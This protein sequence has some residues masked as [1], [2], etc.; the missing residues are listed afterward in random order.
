MT[1]IKT[2]TVFYSIQG[3]GKYAGVPSV[4]VRTFGCNFRCKSFGIR[5]DTN[6]SKHNAEVAEI[7][8]NLSTYATIDDMP[9]VTTGCDS[10]SSV[11]PEFKS[12]AVDYTPEAL[13]SKVVSLLPYKEWRDEHLV[14][15]GGE[16]LLGWQD[17]YPA[18]LDDPQMDKL[19]FLTFETN[20]TQELSPEFTR[21]LLSWEL[22]GDAKNGEYVREVTFSVSPKL[23]CSGE[24][25][26]KA[27]LPEIV[28]AYQDAGNVFLKFV[29]TDAIDVEE[30]L[31]YI[32]IYRAAGVVCPV[33]LMAEGG[34][35]SK[36]NLNTREVADLALKHGLRYSPRL[37]SNLFSNR[38]G[39]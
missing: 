9:L 1:K 10:Y 25:F 2:S 7:I 21:Y 27:I 6:S 12:Y 30:A 8:K 35:E 5:N 3:E 28:N 20:G 37:Q 33:Y 34:T 39:T 4:F 38:W 11:Y 19:N 32:D 23:K 14:I 31:E 15:T 29:V 22:D 17:L 16:P 18:L 24:S 26:S 36:H 13:A